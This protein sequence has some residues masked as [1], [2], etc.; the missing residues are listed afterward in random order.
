MSTQCLCVKRVARNLESETIIGAKLSSAPTQIKAKVSSGSSI[1]A[2]LKKDINVKA[3]VQSFNYLQ[4]PYVNAKFFPRLRC[5]AKLK[6][7]ITSSAEVSA[8]L[9]AS[10]SIRQSIESV[11]SI[12]TITKKFNGELPSYGCSQKLYPVADLVTNV[13]TNYFVNEGV[14]SGNLYQSIDEGVLS[15]DGGDV[16][17]LTTFISPSSIHTEGNFHYQCSVSKPVTAR[18]STLLMKATAPLYNKVSQLP[19]QYTLHDIKLEDP[20]GKLIISYEDIVIRGDSD[21]NDPS[22]RDLNWN[23]Y[24]SK[25]KDNRLLLDFWHPDYPDLQSDSGYTFKFSLKAHDFD[26]PFDEGFDKGYEENDVGIE[27]QGNASDNDYFAIAAS[28]LAGEFSGPLNPNESVRISAIEICNSGAYGTAVGDRFNLFLEVQPTGQRLQR[29]IKPITF[30]TSDFDPGIWPVSSS[31]WQDNT[32]SIFNNS[33]SE[34]GKLLNILTDEN[35]TNFVELYTNNFGVADSG[36]LILE[37]GHRTPTAVF[38]LMDG[39]FSFGVPISGDFSTAGKGNLPINDNFFLVDSVSLRVKAKKATGSRDYAIDVVGY[40]DDKILSIT[41]ASGGFLQNTT[42]EGTIPTSSGYISTDADAL[43]AESI[44]DYSEYYESDTTNNAGGD[45]YKLPAAVVDSTDFSWYDIPLKVYDDTVTVGKS[46]DYSMSTYFEHI[47]LDIF[48]FPSG[49]AIADIEL[50]VNF[51]PTDAIKLHT[52]GGEKI[53]II[54]GDH[55]KEEGKIYPSSR[56]SSDSMLNTGPDYLP[57]SK[58]Q[59][60]PHGYSTPTSMK[61]NYSRR[62]RGMDG[63]SMSAFEN[64]FGLAFHRSYIDSPFISGYFDFNYDDGT[65]IKPR[66]GTLEGTLTTTYADHHIENIGLR[67][68]NPTLFSSKIPSHSCDYE[69]I[70]W[71]ALANGSDNF[72]S[73]ELYGRISD[74]F[75]NAVRLSGVNSYIDFGDVDIENEFSMFVRFSPDVDVSGAGF[76]LFDSGVIASKWQTG[77]DLEFA[78]GYDDGYL[79][80]TARDAGGSEVQIK[81]T[82]KYSGYYYPLSVVVTYEEGDKFPLKLYTDNEASSNWNTLR[83]SGG[84]DTFNLNTGSSSLH[85]GNSTGSG[86]GMNMFVTDF[87]L[88]NEANVKHSDPDLDK[89]Q[90]TADSFLSNHRLKFWNTGES[91]TDDT[92]KIWDRLN[93]DTRKW[94]I[95]A[96]KYCEFSPDFNI[97]TKKEGRDFVRFN[98]KHDGQSYIDKVD[99]ATPVNVPSG[100]AYHTQL[101]NDFLRFNLSDAHERFHSIGPRISKDLPRGYKF[102]ERALVVET[103]LEHHTKNTFAWDD[104]SIGPKLIVSL[105]TRNQDLDTYTGNRGLISRAIHNLPASGC[106]HRIDSTFTKESLLYSE[107]PWAVFPTD[108]HVTEF[109]KH[110]YGS[111][112]IDKM[113]LQYDLVY[114]SGPSFESTLDIHT[115]HIRLEQ[116]FLKASGINNL[117]TSSGTILFTSGEFVG[118]SKVNFFLSGSSGINNLWGDPDSTTS[119]LILHTICNPIANSGLL[120]LSTF[121]RTNTPISTVN[122]HTQ[123]IG[124]ADNLLTSSGTTLFTSGQNIT[125][126]S[127][128][129]YLHNT[130]AL[131][132]GS[133]SLSTSGTQ[134]QPHSTLSM[135]AFNLGKP[136]SLTSGNFNLFLPAVSKQESRFPSGVLPLRLKGAQT[137]SSKINLFL[138]SEK[139]IHTL[140]G[141][142]N[143]HTVSYDRLESGVNRFE[144]NGR[145]FGSEITVDDNTYASKS[146]DDEIRGVEIICHG[147]CDSTSTNKCEEKSI[148][149][150]DTL[151]LGKS[152][153]DGGIFRAKDT[154]TNTEYSYSG[155]YYG[156]RKY[157]GLAPNSLYNITVTAKTG[158]TTPITPPNEFEE[159]E[160]GSN[161]DV[162]FSGVK[163]LGDFPHAE[164]GRNIN[165]QYGT[166]VAVNKDLM[167]VGS[168]YHN[169]DENG[170][171]YLQDAGAVFAYR[172]ASGVNTG[173][174]YG[175]SLEQ[176]ICLPSGFRDPFYDVVPS[177]VS[178]PGGNSYEE[179]KWQVGQKGRMLGHSIAVAASGD[180]EVAVIGAPGAAWSGSFDT[181]ETSGVN[182]GAIVITDEFKPTRANVSDIYSQVVSQNQIYRYFS[183]PAVELDLK[184]IICETKPYEDRG[185]SYPEWVIHQ[186]IDRNYVDEA[187]TSSILSGIKE[188]FNRAFP[189]KDA[190]H[191][192]LPPMIGIYVDPSPSFGRESVEPAID[193][194]IQYYKDY[195]FLSGVVN[196]YGVQ[197]SGHVYEHFMKDSERDFFGNPPESWVDFSKTLVNELLDSGRVGSDGS[198]TKLITSGV[199]P[200]H[201]NPQLSEFNTPA[202]S[203]GRVYVF[204][205]IGNI[206]DLTQEINSPAESSDHYQDFFGH[207]VGISDNCE[208]ITIGSPYKDNQS[209]MIYEYKPEER[210]KV[211]DNLI[212]WLKKNNVDNKFDTDLESYDT[213]KKTMTEREAAKKVY[214]ELSAHNRLTYR[215]DVDFFGIQTSG[216]ASPMAISEYKEIYSYGHENINYTGTWAFIAYKHAGTSRLGYST[217]VNQDGTKVAFGAPTDSFNEFDDTNVWYRKS[218]IYGYGDDAPR[219]WSPLDG[220]AS[221]TNTGAVRVFE[222]RKYHPHSGVVEYYKFGNLH[223]SLNPQLE[224]S[225]SFGFSGV[226]EGRDVTRTGFTEVSIPKSAGLAYIITPEVD[227]SS[228]EIIGEIK[229][230]L[231][232]GDRTLVLV[233]NDPTWEANGAY[234]QS[235]NI[236]NKILSK[237]GSHMRLHAARGRS[238]SLPD[239]PASGKPNVIRSKDPKYS[240]S[241]DI[242]RYNMYAKGVADI[243]MHIPDWD[244]KAYD[245]TCLTGEGGELLN[246]ACPMPLKH[247]GDLRAQKIIECS[248]PHPDPQ[249]GRITIKEYINWP[250]LFGNGSAGCD[251]KSEL[252]GVIGKPDGEPKPLSAAAEYLPASSIV[253]PASTETKIVPVYEERVFEKNTTRIEYSFSDNVGDKKFEFVDPESSGLSSISEVRFVNPESYLGRD[254]RLQGVG[255]TKTSPVVEDK[256]VAPESVLLAEQDWSYT[257]KLSKVV[258]LASVTTEERENLYAGADDNILLYQNILRKSC[259]NYKG[260]IAQLGGWTGRTS[261]KD[262][263]AKSEV[264]TMLASKGYSITNNVQGAIPDIYDVCWVANPNGIASEDDIKHIK[265]FLNKGDKKL[266]ITYGVDQDVARNVKILSNDLELGMEPLYLN[267]DKVFA[268]TETNSAKVATQQT[269]NGTSKIISGCDRDDVVRKIYISDA[270]SELA[271]LEPTL[272][273]FI[274]IKITGNAT[275]AAKTNAAIKDTITK[276]ESIWQMKPGVANLTAD[277]L[278]GS[279]YRMYY[280]WV[281]EDDTEYLPIEITAENVLFD[282]DPRVPKPDVGGALNDYDNND[283]P[284]VVSED[285]QV[286]G[287][288]S[289]PG[290]GRVKTGHLDFRIPDTST[291]LNIFLDGNNLRVAE[292]DELD[293]VPKTV[294]LVGVSGCLLPIIKRTINQTVKEKRSV[295]V[296]WKKVV[297]VIPEKV[298]E[299][300]AKFQPIKTNAFKYCEDPANPCGNDMIDDGPIVVAEEIEEFSTFPAGKR[301]SNIVLISDVSI[302]QDDCGEHFKQ[303][304]AEFMQSL[305]PRSLDA[306]AGDHT[307]GAAA[308]ESRF[309]GDGRFF[310]H[311]QK[312]KSPEFGSPFR[313]YSASGLDNLGKLFGE[314]DTRQASGFFSGEQN[315]NPATIERPQPPEKESKRRSEESQFESH[316]SS[317]FGGYVR[318][319][320][321]GTHLDGGIER[322]FP[323]V[324]SDASIKS[325]Y[326]DSE[327]FQSGYVG[328]LF[329]F[330]ID[331]DKDGLVVGAP[332][333]GY[334]SES[335]VDWDS[336]ITFE[337][338]NNDL[339]DGI[340]VCGKGGGGAAFYYQRTGSGVS[341][342]G[343]YLPWQFI[344]KIK[345]SSVNVGIDNYS[346]L[347]ESQ[348]LLGTN[349]YTASDLT[350]LLVI[351]DEFGYSVSLDADAMAIGAPGHD[352]GNH[353]EH[354]FTRDP[355]GTPT[356]TTPAFSGQFIRKAFNSEFDIPLHKVYDLGT[357]GV[358]IDS[359]AGS[360]GTSVL[361]NGAVFTFENK[362][363]SYRTREKQWQFK[364]KIIAQGNKAR[365]QKAYT[366]DFVPVAI[367]GSENDNFGKSV[368]IDRVYRSDS[369]YTLAVGAPY[370]MFSSGNVASD[371]PIFQAGAAY[372]YDAM[373]REQPKVVPVVGSFITADIFGDSKNDGN[374]SITVEQPSSGDPIT[375]QQSGLIASNTQG[376]IFIE[377]SG[378]DLAELGFIQHRP[379]IDSVVGVTPLGT[380][381]FSA[382]GLHSDGAAPS[383]SG[384]INL[385][386]AGPS[387][388]TVYNN[389]ALHTS[390]AYNASGQVNLTVWTPSGNPNSGLM[391][392]YTSG[393]AF[394]TEN[395]N[396]RVRG[397]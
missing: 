77:N 205:K 236:I 55:D 376:E 257:D 238:E 10:L 233:G 272:R 6:S 18:H 379:Y 300:P 177:A 266:I 216:E 187:T 232:L 73:H 3:V 35:E 38:G 384:S 245:G 389:I 149:T 221:T 240:R 176:K 66:F 271:G 74:G 260:R 173:S 282:P 323:S 180:R 365:A 126:G 316:V 256:V 198:A 318:L 345:P 13:G 120:N 188:G 33:E 128:N 114:P 342:A 264:A 98:I 301:R 234:G 383:T 308:G 289:K 284:F 171:G 309:T 206:W 129:A 330:S 108:R 333:N 386:L 270:Y 51:K 45:H 375:Y 75:N 373:L 395:V 179:R 137:P 172:R 230:W 369:D 331:M 22:T 127:I 101:E 50:C 181:I 387:E 91:H 341:N 27:I 87:G 199:G 100:V 71:T 78:L 142:S 84:S 60:I 348:V 358:R 303:D 2:V 125:I 12:K 352:Y 363:L 286:S 262:A 220:W 96:F 95:G 81:D 334:D 169:W 305:Y 105:Y 132:S 153:T 283:Q 68:K 394:V 239:C 147:N 7:S 19:P 124:I 258:M 44:S 278:A 110:K 24:A 46:P 185:V 249:K 67:F 393:A 26:D 8:P 364:E 317:T 115:A 332:Y 354:I 89:Y 251:P 121:G 246:E 175:W 103:V 152:C 299:I 86:V 371:D 269:V 62:W 191:S 144:W 338:N 243:R 329:G 259:P 261:L 49:A 85:L 17:D 165:D 372:T 355:D 30:K 275:Y 356:T 5:D 377:A 200:E 267:N 136:A 130:T 378:K 314:L 90:V 290:I 178:L 118:R 168:P 57:I 320:G 276:T 162:N 211:Y 93:K 140:S 202:F 65:S 327:Y 161:N 119:G 388:G 273:E 109:G 139:E 99:S 204:E 145:T 15:A 219:Y 310:E 228:D 70:D 293:Y 167:L 252:E 322:V 29:C 281:A 164:S 292:A 268:S 207:S 253:F 174:K 212:T 359:V 61:S 170:S 339:V 344:T 69:T 349:N 143:L 182:I 131:S 28:P 390:S 353:H 183:D 102:S 382:M 209:C 43:S 295:Q 116:A 274:P 141:I 367:S 203:G 226:Y 297:E 210:V 39:E 36:K 225:G 250:W 111:E 41:S 133:L 304:N 158:S 4:S 302:I 335:I 54:S 366:E 312:I 156:I 104:G 296:G 107:E 106:L 231:A 194:F 247:N 215:K 40:S 9:K 201:I 392:L 97:L 197:S 122:L 307:G 117:L 214:S 83:A 385:Y 357:S 319:S 166:T 16:S 20:A 340:K 311:T 123:N 155:D 76:N 34:A 42:G 324:M 298:I 306:L 64:D 92:Y 160:Y 224:P 265:E 184:L 217:A 242:S 279:G 241:T 254:A 360:S 31:V 294:R 134:Y 397:K 159:W 370:H 237:L 189:Y 336:S 135:V 347:S 255:T 11:A 151:W 287:S 343:G 112:D 368:S 21:Y 82:V 321:V 396:L 351:P 227:A 223:R 25:P 235:N 328:D 313:F 186:K 1:T 23:I 59:S 14:Q 280:S 218:G 263:H 148:E 288:M 248:K 362:T 192:G 58:I 48:P 350:D 391:S 63:E 52:I 285:I 244:R 157:T 56:Q 88:S 193:E 208:V 146:A 190:V 337:A 277:V 79:A 229:D 72:E 53:Q 47:T 196:F 80:L 374:V 94:D 32:G 315:P 113:F 325:D 380:S 346:D 381:V 163:F 37:F 154:Y 291:S 222:S 138:K 326:L 213:Y 361:A 150:H 195:T